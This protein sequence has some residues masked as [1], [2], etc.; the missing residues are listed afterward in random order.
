MTDARGNMRTFARAVHVTQ[1]SG[2]IFLD[3]PTPGEGSTGILVVRGWAFSR[4]A[5]IYNV[6]VFLGDRLLGAVP[7]GLVRTDVRDLFDHPYA[8]NSGFH[9]I[10]RFPVEETGPQVIAV[11]A[12]DLRGE[13]I[14]ITV[15]VRIITVDEPLAKIERATWR[16]GTVDVEGWAIWPR[17]AFPRVAH[18]FLDGASLGEARLN[19]SRPDVAMR[20]PN[21]PDA[22]RSGFRFTRTIAGPV[23]DARQPA[24]LV[25]E[26]TD[27]SGQVLYAR[28]HVAPDPDLP[29]VSPDV[30]ETIAALIDGEQGGST[31]IPPSS[32]GTPASP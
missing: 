31:A 5:P 28:S 18:L 20:F 21:N 10:L 1:R 19:L 29:T 26:F 15:P 6:Q 11:R 27:G 22:A 9:G 13:V 17:S 14:E 2:H 3:E 16:G 32:I 30:A 24:E 23:A 7:H 4:K 25:V 12:T 8:K